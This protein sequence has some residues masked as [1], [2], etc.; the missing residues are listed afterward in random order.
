MIEIR[1]ELQRQLKVRSLARAQREDGATISN[2]IALEMDDLLQGAVVYLLNFRFNK[3]MP[4]NVGSLPQVDWLKK[5][6]RLY[7]S[8]QLGVTNRRL[9]AGIELAFISGLTRWLNVTPQ[10][11]VSTI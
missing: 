4:A 1:D 6:W 5:S 11:V 9:M 3:L 7:A 2:A 10:F 8:L